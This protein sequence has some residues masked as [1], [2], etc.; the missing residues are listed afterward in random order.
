LR[1]PKSVD[2]ADDSELP[3]VSVIVYANDNAAELREMLPE[4][5]NQN[6][7]AGK[8]EVIVVNDGS[9]DDITDVVNYLGQEYRNLYITFVPD[10]ATTSVAR[11]WQSHSASR[12]PRKRLYC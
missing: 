12:P 8:L 9:V 3:G 10:Q 2:Q 6:Y 5:L 4:V 11:S 1:L 7:P